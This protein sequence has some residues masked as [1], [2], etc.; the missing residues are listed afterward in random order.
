MKE[1]KTIKPSIREVKVILNS[2]GIDQKDIGRHYND[3]RKSGGRIKLFTRYDESPYASM[4]EHRLSNMF[5]EYAIDVNNYHNRGMTV[6]FNKRYPG[7]T[8][9]QHYRKLTEH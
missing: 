9:C 1:N 3:Q 8:N 5:P 7:A 2:L 4:L 6:H